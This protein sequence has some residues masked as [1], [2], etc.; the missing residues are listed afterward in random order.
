MN[1]CWAASVYISLCGYECTTDIYL[2]ECETVHGLVWY[3][4][5]CLHVH[6][7]AQ[8]CAYECSILRV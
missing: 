4:N 2:Y 1:V 8:M 7:C 5:V 6:V 3:R